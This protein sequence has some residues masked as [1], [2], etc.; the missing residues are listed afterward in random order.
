MTLILDLMPQKLTLIFQN[1]GLDIQV[2]QCRI[3]DY[4]FKGKVDS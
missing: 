2:A 1:E 4:R 3:I